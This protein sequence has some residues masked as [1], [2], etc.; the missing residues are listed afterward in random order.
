MNDQKVDNRNK[1]DRTRFEKLKFVAIKLSEI[2]YNPEYFY[3]PGFVS[4]I[5]F[6][7]L[8]KYSRILEPNIN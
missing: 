7:T 5:F 6:E 1:S 2:I 3:H 4:N 8:F